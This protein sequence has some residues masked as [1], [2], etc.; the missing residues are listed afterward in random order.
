[1]NNNIYRE[2]YGT[3]S[4]VFN[5]VLLPDVQVRN[6][7][8]KRVGSPAVCLS[9]RLVAH[10][11]STIVILPLVRLMLFLWL[12]NVYATIGLVEADTYEVYAYNGPFLLRA[13]TV[14]CQHVDSGGVLLKPDA[15]YLYIRPVMRIYV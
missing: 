4:C 5:V 3:C 13:D 7:G 2:C 1:M 12:S 15:H 8:D 14:T 10:C 6:R 11:Y 9:S